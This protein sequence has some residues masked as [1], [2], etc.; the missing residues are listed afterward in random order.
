VFD[1]LVIEEMHASPRGY[2]Q[3]PECVKAVVNFICLSRLNLWHKWLYRFQELAGLTEKECRAY[4][5]VSALLLIGAI[6]RYL[7]KSSL[8]FDEAYYT[9]LYQEFERL[10]SRADSF[11]RAKEF[12]ALAKRPTRHARASINLNTASREELQTLPRVGPALSSR[13]LDLRER[14]GAFMDVS[15]L[16][17]VQGIGE[18]TLELIRDSLFVEATNPDEEL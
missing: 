10:S 1:S 6:A 13:I 18:K 3:E 5:L 9:P 11:D 2:V 15:D 8:V 4:F 7:P 14:L 17:M 12:K 16:L